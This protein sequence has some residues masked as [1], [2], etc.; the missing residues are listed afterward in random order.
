MTSERRQRA[1]DF[2]LD[3]QRFA[4]VADTVAGAKPEHTAACAT[5][6][7]AFEAVEALAG[8]A[9]YFETR[10]NARRRAEQCE[11]EL[12]ALHESGTCPVP[13]DPGEQRYA[14]KLRWLDRHADCCMSDRSAAFVHDWD[15]ADG[16]R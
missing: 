12:L 8:E 1:I 2:A 14:Q 10:M 6:R 11:R 13:L 5:L 7:A 9:V 15:I 4:R 16:T 3:P